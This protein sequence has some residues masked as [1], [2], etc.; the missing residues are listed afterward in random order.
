MSRMIN[1]LRFTQAEPRDRRRD[2]AAALAAHPDDDHAALMYLHA[3]GYDCSDAR[4]TGNR[5]VVPLWANG[6]EDYAVAILRGDGHDATLRHIVDVGPT[7]D[8]GATH[9]TRDGLPLTVLYKPE[10]GY[11]VAV[12]TP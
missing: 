2:E 11:N 5:F 12:H 4:V 1:G 10:H 9:E 6:R 7:E 8:S 3:L